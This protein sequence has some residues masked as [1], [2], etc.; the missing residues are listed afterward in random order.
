MAKKNSKAEQIGDVLQ[1]LAYHEFELSDE[2]GAV[3]IG[4]YGPSARVEAYISD[5]ADKQT[6][7]HLQLHHSLSFSSLLK[8]LD[9]GC[10]DSE[11]LVIDELFGSC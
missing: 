9:L 4:D 11:F 2:T 10:F 3:H 8:K 6:E 5:D 7:Q 1:A